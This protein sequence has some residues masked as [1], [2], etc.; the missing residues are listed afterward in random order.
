MQFQ[1]SRVRFQMPQQVPG[2]LEGAR[3]RITF[4]L[5][6]STPAISMTTA[7]DRLFSTPDTVPWQ[8]SGTP[9]DSRRKIRSIPYHSEVSRRRIAKAKPGFDDLATASGIHKTDDEELASWP[10]SGAVRIKHPDPSQSSPS[11]HAREA[12]RSRHPVSYPPPS[13][14]LAERNQG[15]LGVHSQQV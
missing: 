13:S 3:C 6:V 12:W 10:G 9:S 15:T 14:S 8:P 1:P 4:L 5:G 7:S 11:W 2:H